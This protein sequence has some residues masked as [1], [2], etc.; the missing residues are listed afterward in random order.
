[1]V[2]LT[3]CLLQRPNPP[4]MRHRQQAAQQYRRRNRIYA[5]GIHNSRGEESPLRKGLT[6]M[7]GAEMQASKSS[8]ASSCVHCRQVKVWAKADLYGSPRY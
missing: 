8:R 5:R 2:H 3:P 6:D 7:L 4:G 1:M